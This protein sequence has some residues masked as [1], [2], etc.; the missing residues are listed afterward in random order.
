MGRDYT[1]WWVDEVPGA[2][3]DAESYGQLH[4]TANDGVIAFKSGR[5][6]FRSDR[7]G[8]WLERLLLPLAQDGSR[9]DIIL[10]ITA[11]GVPVPTI[12]RI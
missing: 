6:T 4:I 10:A 2:A 8:P 3:P 9:V 5:P 12:N 11:Y 7:Y 1:R